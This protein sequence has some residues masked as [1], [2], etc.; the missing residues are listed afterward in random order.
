MMDDDRETT[1]KDEQRLLEAPTA[2]YPVFD[3]TGHHAVKEMPILGLAQGLTAGSEDSPRR[4]TLGNS[5][6]L[7]PSQL[8][9]SA[10]SITMPTRLVLISRAISSQLSLSTEVYQ[11]FQNAPSVSCCIN[12]TVINIRICIY[13]D[14]QQNIHKFYST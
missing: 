9:I 2:L 14:H 12:E 7:Q 10:Q 13:R 8:D 4:T 3:I 11:E 5:A 6:I 1:G